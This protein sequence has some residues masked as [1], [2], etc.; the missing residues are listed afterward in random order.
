MGHNWAL[1]VTV[2]W[3][4]S[5]PCLLPPPQPISSQVGTSSS[6]ALGPVLSGLPT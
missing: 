2:G 6:F 5:T 4:S 3:N 1:E